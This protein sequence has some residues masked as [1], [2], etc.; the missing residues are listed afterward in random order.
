MRWKRRQ[1]VGGG[2]SKNGVITLYMGYN[3]PYM[4]PIHTNTSIVLNNN[5]GAKRGNSRMVDTRRKRTTEQREE[6]LVLVA[7][8]LTRECLSHT[9]IQKRLGEERNYSLSLAT[10]EK[11]IKDLHMRW[12]AAYLGETNELMARELKRIDN[13]EAAYWDSYER[14]LSNKEI[15]KE[16]EEEGENT[17]LSTTA[18]PAGKF[19]K[20][21][22][23]R[24]LHQRDGGVQFLDGI[25]WCINQRCDILG[26]KAPLKSEMI[27]DWRSEAQRM[28]FDPGRIFNDV[29]QT[30]I[31]GNI[32]ETVEGNELNSMIAN[33]Q[34]QLEEHLDEN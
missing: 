21:K 4:T 12:R 1:K 31:D 5:E 29:V 25:K 23:A 8:L 6:D 33:Y 34:A 10:I 13:L 18:T 32:V 24:E 16:E 15:I 3:K 2:G 14:S 7:R 20:R 19:K 30:F 9:E 26:L 27:L 17:G 28:G 11:D 22:S